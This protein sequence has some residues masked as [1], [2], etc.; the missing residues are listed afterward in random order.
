M[1]ADQRTVLFDFDGT[2]ADSAPDLIAALNNW[3]AVRNR[4]PIDAT[5]ARNLCSGGSRAL[6]SFCG[7]GDEDFEQAKADYLRRYEA[8]GYQH[9]V[10]FTGIP[11]ILKQLNQMS[12]TWGIVTNK[13]RR[14]FA[15]IAKRLQLTEL[16]AKIFVCGDDHPHAKPHPQ[17]LLAAAAACNTP[18][19][20]CIYVGDDVRDA[21]AAASAAMLFIGTT[22]GYWQPK[23]WQNSED[24][25]PIGAY[26]S[27]PSALSK[28]LGTSAMVSTCASHR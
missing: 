5:A 6:L 14:Y 3:L 11:E 12:I 25:P 13:P 23:Q 26:V 17:P 16:G 28:M 21:K 7:L 18:P 4:Q 27:T 10:L 8:T 9:T 24:M 22:W 15:A 19:T 20:Q 2:L 1:T